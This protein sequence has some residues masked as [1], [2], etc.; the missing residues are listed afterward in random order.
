MASQQQ[1]CRFAIISSSAGHSAMKTEWL[2]NA[3]PNNLN[4]TNITMLPLMT[5][6]KN[7]NFFH[8]KYFGREEASVKR[9]TSKGAIN[10]KKK[11]LDDSANGTE[12]FC[13][14]IMAVNEN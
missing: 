3:S 11:T 7:A 5:F 8:Q 2:L 4:N 13:V 6:Q 10:K 1:K 14:L 12:H 9:G